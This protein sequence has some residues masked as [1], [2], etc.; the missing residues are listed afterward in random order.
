MNA[1]IRRQLAKHKRRIAR[2]LEKRNNDGCEQ[3]MFTAAN[4]HYEIADRM[5]GVG[6]G[7]IGAMHLLARRLGL[8][9][10]LD[11]RLHVLKIHLPYHESDHVL[12]MAYNVLA[13]GACLDHLELL[14]NDENYLDALGA[15][16]IPDPT[17]AGD[18]CRRFG[19]S[20][21]YTLRDVM[22]RTSQK[23]WAAQGDSDF[24]DQAI[25]D[26]DGVI[27]ETSGECKQGMDISYNGRWGYHP[28]VV[29]LANTG[30][31]LGLV[32]RPGNRP[33][34]EG[35][36]AALDCA[37][38]VCLEAGF[39]RA[40]L[41]GDNDFT[42]TKQ[43]DRWDASGRVEFIFGMD[44]I[45]KL[46]ILADDLPDSAWKTLKRP[47]RYEVKTQPRAKPDNVK[48]QIVRRRGY[49]S[50]HLLWEDVAEME[51][52][53]V[54]CKKAYRLIVV[55]KNLSRERG[56][57][58]QRQFFSD[59]RYFFY[60]TNIW[61][62]PAAE[63]VFSANG[64]CNQE[65]NVNSQLLGGVRSLTAPLDSLLSN[66]AY[67]LATTLA[68]NLKIWWALC[69]PARAG[70]W[71]PQHR[72]EKRRVLRMEFKTFVNAFMRVPC[73]IIRTSGKLIYRLLAWNPWQ[74]VFFRLF[75]QLRLP[76]HY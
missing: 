57:A 7:G 14:R 5:R 72:E 33:S 24:F 2:R 34:H 58:D 6:C 45:P 56:P 16:R 66:W 64:R 67:M 53:P 20:D 70:P 63:I 4:I 46:Q 8:I 15:R 31:V 69:L 9:E 12:N 19:E 65:H 13:G 55:R 30:E 74:H 43:L 36:A 42:Q 28:L 40:L 21:I 32:N 68:W 1:K 29:S 39:L 44:A 47:P 41:R 27:V 50:I 75:D 71:Q 17:T 35:A 23:A 54:A 73:Q 26:V 25:I 61:E 48:Q 60:L 10:A 22:N 38:D 51:Y 59:Y 3:P 11:E 49:E 76:Q 18:F 62:P 52:R 37:I